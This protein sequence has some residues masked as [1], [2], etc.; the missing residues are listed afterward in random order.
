M[1]VKMDENKIIAMREVSD[2][3]MNKFKKL[4]S[5]EARQ[6]K[7][8]YTNP[9]LVANIISMRCQIIFDLKVEDNNKK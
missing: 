1:V 7:N 3:H 9:L 2:E 6:I 8:G 5:L 4:D